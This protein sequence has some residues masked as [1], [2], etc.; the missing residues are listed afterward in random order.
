MYLTIIIHSTLDFTWSKA[1]S[2]LKY[3]F[4]KNK[5]WKSAPEVWPNGS[6]SYTTPP[7]LSTSSLPAHRDCL[8]SKYGKA[9]SSSTG[10]DL[11]RDCK[12]SLDMSS[13]SPPKQPESAKHGNGIWNEGGK[14]KQNYAYRKTIKI[15]TRKHVESCT[16]L[17][18]V[19][20]YVTYNLWWGAR[21]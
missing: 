12:L 16:Y 11:S 20:S 8:G 19:P 10:N 17:K 15:H 2:T 13:D 14:L 21:G 3:T 9:T 4:K 7:F 6:P 5:I 1:N 18:H